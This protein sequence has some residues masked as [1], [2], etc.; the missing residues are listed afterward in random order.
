MLAYSFWTVPF[1]LITSACRPNSQKQDPPWLQE[2]PWGQR[3]AAN[4]FPTPAS[5]ASA[6]M[7]HPPLQLDERV[8]HFGACVNQL[9]ISITL[10][11]FSLSDAR[12][13]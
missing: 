1:A 8:G 6:T 9:G 7:Q 13:L 3:E 12:L 4:L 10:V 11:V 5:P 2:Q